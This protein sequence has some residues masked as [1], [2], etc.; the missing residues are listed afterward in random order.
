MVPAIGAGLLLFILCAELVLSARRQS[1]TSDEACHILAGYRSWKN[2][3]FGIN[4]EHPPL[5]KLVAAL[6]LL[7][8]PLQVPPLPRGFF[9]GVEFLGGE[10][11]L[12][13]N[14]AG[15]ILFSARMA[16]AGFTIALAI[17]V[18]VSAYFVWGIGPALMALTLLVFEPNVLAHGALVTTDLGVTFGLFFAVAA[19]SAH[20]KNPGVWKI[21]LTGFAA[22]MALSTKHSGVL[23]LPI[24]VLLAAA[25]WWLQ[26]RSARTNRN[27]G[28]LKPAM[29]LAASL[30]M[31]FAIA[32]AVLWACYGF[33]YAARPHGLQIDPPLSVSVS[34]G[35]GISSRLVWDIAQLK[36]LPESYLYGFADVFALSG[37][38]PT[39]LFG[40]FYTQAQWF[41]FP[42]V[43]IIKLTLGFLLLLFL[44]PFAKAIFQKER[45]RDTMFLLIP[46]IFY[47]LVAMNSGVNFGVRHILPSFPFLIVLAAAGAWNLAQRG[48]GFAVLIVCLVVLH[49]VSSIRAFPDYI[50][51]SNE[52]WGGPAKTYRVLSDSNVDW[53]Q[54]LI[55][56]HRYID[57]NKIKDCWFAYFGSVIID[58]SYYGISCQPLPTSFERLAQAPMPVIPAAI[59]GTIFISAS[60]ISGP[61]WGSEALNPYVG[62][63][64][65]QPA[66]VIAGS[67]L[68]FKGR[69]GMSAA[70]ALTHDRTSAQLLQNGE[71]DRALAEAETAV[72][73]APMSP[74]AHLARGN[75]LAKMN[76]DADAAK[77][78]EIADRLK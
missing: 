49:I 70:A 48:R 30:A 53:S 10:K 68:V 56:M 62:F 20:L 36:L 39:F 69:N 64:Q 75:A 27:N 32:L 29:R 11:F 42:S 4:P 71:F 44:L 12:Y 43:L 66:A 8:L 23:V 45:L 65:K 2:F 77:E 5:V 13:S 41:Y 73:L 57:Q 7:R 37:T 16:A 72:S 59:D 18:F 67:I 34:E 3:D 26:S 19:Y 21:V 25:E 58:P 22:G 17:A 14:D 1:Q 35:N 6:P 60:E 38:T 31:I 74:D 28:F 40:K 15:A 46:A 52:I 9:R 55:S 47:I 51:Y 61:L 24:L 63:R 54:G 50:S 76:R 78:F 33:R